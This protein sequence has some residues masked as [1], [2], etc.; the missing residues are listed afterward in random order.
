MTL[1]VL[2]LPS[3]T[4]C[5]TKL[6]SA[7]LNNVDTYVADI[8]LLYCTLQK[9]RIFWTLLDTQDV[10]LGQ[11]KYVL[12]DECWREL[13]LYHPRWSPRELQ[14]AEERYLRACKAPAVF[15]QLPRWK[16]PFVQLHTMGRF[17]ISARVHDILRSVFFHAAYAENLSE[18][19]APEGLLFIAL[20]LLALALD[21]CALPQNKPGSGSSVA[22]S[23]SPAPS[24]GFPSFDLNTPSYGIPS[25]TS[26]DV[27]DQPPLLVRAVERVLVG[28]ADG[29][30]M[31]EHQSTLSLLVLLLRKFST[32]DGAGVAAGEASHYSVGDLIKSL[33]L[34]FAE[35][36]KPCM[37]EIEL[38]APEIL[39]R[40]S[41]EAAP[42]AGASGEVEKD[43]A[44]LSEME[45][46]RAMARQRQAAVMVSLELLLQTRVKSVTFSS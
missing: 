20:H 30:M 31:A 26:S 44:L 5:P 28:R 33:L 8:V 41:A 43:H 18:S 39:H 1:L 12:R 23:Q 24:S 15:L 9:W 36:N 25:P 27:Q 17:V 13:D 35:L 4:C 3:D 6:S 42:S 19:R 10:L 37:Y 46:R 45:R 32:G 16:A 14:S 34:R 40:V 22:E 11:G 21:V 2:Y 7:R 29:T 38:L